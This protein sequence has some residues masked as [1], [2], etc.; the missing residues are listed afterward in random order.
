MKF[1]APQTQKVYD[2]LKRGQSLTRLTAMHYGVMN[3]TARITDLRK[4]GVSIKCDL[5]HDLNGNR[6]GSFYMRYA[7]GA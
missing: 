3:L 6:Y 1:T 2:L 4:A 5:K 7:R